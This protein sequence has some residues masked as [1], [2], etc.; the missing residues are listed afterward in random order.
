M[1]W[2]V[3]VGWL[4]AERERR[5]WVCA[6]AIP[7]LCQ[8]CAAEGCEAWFNKAGGNENAFRGDIAIPDLQFDSVCASESPALLDRTAP[9]TDAEIHST[10]PADRVAFLQIPVGL[11]PDPGS[12]AR[13]AI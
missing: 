6:N 11:L 1:A 9:P 4:E 10:L 8:S 2:M 7:K 12:T 3:G 13:H 5:L